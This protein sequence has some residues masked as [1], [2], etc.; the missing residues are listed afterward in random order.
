MFGFVVQVSVMTGMIATMTRLRAP[1]D[2]KR[3][4]VGIDVGTNSV[5]MAALE[6][7]ALGMPIDLLSAISQIHDSGVLEAK[8]ATTRLAA[9][10]VARRVRR[11]RRKRVRRLAELDRRLIE[12]GW[13]DGRQTPGTDPY[14][15]WR[16]RAQLSSEVIG[17]EDE[18]SALLAVALRHIARHRGWRNPYAKASQFYSPSEP[19]EFFAG[20]R[21]RVEETTGKTF[22]DGVTVAELAVAAIDHDRRLPLRMGK[23]E[24]ARTERSFSYLG[25]KL[26]Q[27]DN[28][29]E[30]HAWARMQGISHSLLR[31]LVDLVFAAESPR[32][33]WVGKVGKDPLDPAHPRASKATDAFQRF[34]IV[35]ALANLR[36][37][38]GS[39]QRM[40]TLAERLSAYEW[41]LRAKPGSDPTWTEV[42][43]HLGLSRGVLSGAAALDDRAEERLPLR[44]PVHSSDH[45]IQGAKKELA[46]L[47]QWWA[48]AEGDV[49]DA[50]IDLLTDVRRDESTPA[51][52]A[53]WE[54]LNELDE[55]ALAALDGLDLPAGRGAYSLRSLR[56]LTARMLSSTDDLHTARKVVFGVDDSW[57]PPAEPIGAPVGNPAVDRVTKITARWLQAAQAEWGDPERITI[58]HVREAFLSEASVRERDREMRRRFDANEKN[59][60]ALKSADLD[61]TR[62]RAA[63]VRRFQAITR[64]KGQCAYCGET[65]TF[66][67]S[68]MD[69]IVPRKGVGSTNTR[70]NLLAVCMSCNRSK[71]NTP[72]AVWAEGVTRPGVSVADA[73]SR[74]KFWTRDPGTSPRAWRLF[75]KEVQ[76]RLARTEDDPEIDARS[77][78]SVAWMANELR[79]R[80]AAH[81][82]ESKVSVYQGAVTA[83]ARQA[84]GIA[85]KIPFIGGGGK[86]RLDR[87][88]HAVDAATVALLD[89]SVARTLAERNNL[90]ASQA[91]RPHDS[92]WRDYRGSGPQ[93][94]ARFDSWR[95]RMEALAALLSRAFGEDRVVVKE[96][97]RLRLG[98][99]RVHEDSIHPLVRRKV[100]DAFSRNEI[101][102]ASTPALWTALTRDPDYD[103]NAGL[104]ANPERRLRVHGT[105]FGAGDEIEFF[106]KPR[107]A[108]AVRGGWA[109]LG[110]VHHARIYRWTERGKVRYGMLRVFAADL[111]QHRHEDLFSVEPKPSWIS[112][113]VAHPSIGRADLSEREYLGW[114]VPGDELLVSE[115]TAPKAPVLGAV[116]RW[117]VRGFED[118]SRLNV[119]PV[120]LAGEGMEQFIAN[121]TLTDGELAEVK[122]LV[123]GKGRRTVSKFFAD[124][125][126][127]IRRDA[128]GRPRIQSN[129]GL[130]VSWQA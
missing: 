19:S 61:G 52:V 44:P 63:D 128:L 83:G 87:R 114:L 125:P 16:A 26:M 13:F 84:A 45:A 73:V 21:Q 78:E 17:D 34:R 124:S 121:V 18:R 122:D 71:G 113:R 74:T 67:T 47:K 85:E 32:G 7:D 90:R 20:Y 51:G 43:K 86:T 127:V 65:I 35:S 102:A 105:H 60:L 55:D 89:E 104:P 39:G 42:A 10:G 5:G 59:R 14:A 100:G 99:G 11:L 82:A 29:N 123:T 130:P 98:D 49:R 6:V 109:Q 108:L 56:L 66:A 62:V 116:R 50:L 118:A 53:A 36:V 64:Q 31:E 3:Y 112:M 110:S 22:N 117:K 24:K 23:T 40:L 58:E 28:A 81:F 37:K 48:S 97:L 101:D 80:V 93:A 115:A 68:E 2:P 126:V 75:L 27:S 107:A 15:P 1:K 70:T 8:T 69:H 103:P 4:V 88:H 79:D 94:I 72:F 111:M 33:S 38:V 30:M 25:G 129:A 119:E 12:L 91:Y 106:D 9:S 92:H 95:V 57:R 76:E 46:A 77:M 96:N 54:L 41:L 120:L